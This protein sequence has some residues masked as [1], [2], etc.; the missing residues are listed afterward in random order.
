VWDAA[1]EVTITYAASWAPDMATFINALMTLAGAL[2]M[3]NPTNLVLG[4]SGAIRLMAA[5][6][7][8]LLFGTQ[9]YF[10]GSKPTTALT[11]ESVLYYYTS[12]RRQI[13]A[14]FVGPYS[15]A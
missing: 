12:G 2:T 10:V 9:W 7:Q 3:A 15:N 14:S 5:A 4:R 1:A 6:D 8:A 13:P 11:G